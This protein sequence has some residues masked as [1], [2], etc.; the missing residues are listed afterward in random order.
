[1]AREWRFPSQLIEAIQHHHDFEAAPAFTQLAAIVSLANR[2]MMLL[3]VGFAK[4]PD[5]NLEEEP[6]AR[7]LKI[8]PQALGGLAEQVKMM[9]TRITA[10]E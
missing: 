7:F 8:D 5:L 10:A 9:L 6:A 2:M 4:D 1:L 3:E